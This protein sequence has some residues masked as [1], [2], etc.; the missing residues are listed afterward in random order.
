MSDV[1]AV[2]DTYLMRLSGELKVGPLHNRIHWAC[3]LAE[4][5]VYA[6]CHINVISASNGKQ[7]Y[8]KQKTYRKHEFE[9]AKDA[10][11]T[12]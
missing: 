7:S 12:D 8:V 9:Y 10:Q 6:L 3:F 11:P 2:A 1:I 4:A 5:A